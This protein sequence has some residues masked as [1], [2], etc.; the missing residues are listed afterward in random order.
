M[1]GEKSQVLGKMEAAKMLV[2]DKDYVG[3]RSKLL[4]L[5]YGFPG[6]KNVPEMIIACE[7]L[8]ASELTI[9]GETDWYWV[10]QVSPKATMSQLKQK[11]EKL[12]TVLEGIK[13]DFPGAV[14]A[15]KLVH[16]AYGVLSDTRD[17][18]V[19]NSKRLTS[20]GGCEASVSI[21]SSLDDSGHHEGSSLNQEPHCSLVYESYASKDTE[22]KGLDGADERSSTPIEVDDSDGADDMNEW[23]KVIS[24]TEVISR[25]SSLKLEETQTMHN[26]V[27]TSMNFDHLE[28]KPL[29]NATAVTDHICDEGIY[30]LDST[31]EHETFEVG[32][33]WVAYDGEKLP[34]RY[35]RINYV[36]ESPFRLDV[37][38]LQPV[39]KTENESKWC[40]IGMPVVCGLFSL[41]EDEESLVDSATLSHL[42][43]CT[44]SPTYDEFEILPQE[45]EVWAVYK[46]WRP[47]DWL[48][49]PESRKG[50]S[51]QV[52]KI[53]E[54]YSDQEGV[55]VVPLVKVGGSQNVY[56][57]ETEVGRECSFR[58]PAN[59][60]YQFSHQLPAHDLEGGKLIGV[61]GE[62]D[63]STMNFS[64]SQ[65]PVSYPSSSDLVGKSP[66][67]EWTVEHFAA[68]QVWA[69][70]HGTDKMP[71][72]YAVVNKVFPSG[73]VEVTFLEPHPNPMDYEEISWIEE[74]LPV[75]CGIFKL[76]SRI[77]ILEFG[78]FSHLVNCDRTTKNMFFRIYPK[79]GE[80]WAMYRNWNRKWKQKD[81]SNY[82]CRIVQI[83]SDFIEP[84]GVHTA[85][86]EEVPGYKTFFQKQQCD[87]FVLNRAVPRS[88]MLSFSHRI[89]AFVVPGI[90]VHGIPECSWHLEPDAL[91]P[92]LS[93]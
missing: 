72:Q 7:I 41:H 19:F 78:K 17:S 79:K 58:I 40:E 43:S 93:N 71:R 24:S 18:L 47:L 34:R 36:S 4:E 57:R 92:V 76:G 62:Q 44:A 87:G 38:W 56:R 80:I 91:P 77:A 14:T 67:L 84:S 37:N 50:C 3:A 31:K 29:P 32:Q 16:N 90:G 22:G 27:V 2:A 85:S 8:C 6:F 39:P 74:N 82:H 52:V 65:R 66:K 13:G 15:L 33:I 1:N 53:L 46:D 26:N 64:T 61:Y 59:Y 54:D 45:D 69:I 42:V 12:T 9:D 86:L 55:L 89:E 48:K 70:Y 51:L 21:A 10:L 28:E 49:N 25:S 60:L 35:A 63:P 81:F 83:T 88:E 23:N 30:N 11:Y 75:G 5:H 68:S 73:A 20:W